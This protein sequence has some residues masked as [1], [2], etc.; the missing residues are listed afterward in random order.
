MTHPDLHNTRWPLAALLIMSVGLGACQT[1]DDNQEISAVVGISNPSWVV[2]HTDT[3][4]NYI[5]L[6]VV[7]E[8]T[9]W[10]SG[11]GG[12]VTRTSDGGKTWTSS[13]VD[14][15]SELAFRDIHAFNDHTAYILSIENE[16]ATDQRIYRTDDAGMSWSLVFKNQD[17]NSFFDCLSFWDERRGMAFSDSFEGE[18]RVIRTLDGGNSWEEVPDDRLPD[19]HPGEGAF[20]ASGT[21]VVTRPGGL[22]WFPTGASG[23]DTRVFRTADYGETWEASP[24]PIKSGSSTAGIFT[25]SFLDDHIGIAMGGDY[26]FPDSLFMNT[27]VTMDGGAT[28]T[29]GGQSNIKGSIFGATYVPGA[30]TPTVIAVAPTGSDYSTDNGQTWTLFSDTNYWSVAGVS[31]AAVWAAGPGQIARLTSGTENTPDSP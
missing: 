10:A 23:I 20:A 4:T 5:G 12:T 6:Y 9:V 18:F 22:G 11:S 30:A 17:E 31:P 7:D 28:W 25:L 29:R 24:T 2:Q 16:N 1:A 27:A 3:T 8:Q 13:V 21:C 19:A 26:L 15:A 14:G